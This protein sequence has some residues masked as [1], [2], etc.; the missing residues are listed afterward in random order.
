LVT[1]GEGF[2]FFGNIIVGLIGG[3]IG[4]FIFGFFGFSDPNFI[5]SIIVSTVGAVILLYFINMFR[6][7]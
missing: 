2:G 6:N 4:N 7:N 3:L 1:K 5:G